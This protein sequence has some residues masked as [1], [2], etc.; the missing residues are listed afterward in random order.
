MRIFTEKKLEFRHPVTGETFAT[1]LK[2]FADAPAWIEKDPLFAWAVK[3]GSLIAVEPAPEIA[4]QAVPAEPKKTA[5]KRKAES[6]KEA[7]AE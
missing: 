6:K 7:D 3:E 1:R 2:A 5:A 4:V